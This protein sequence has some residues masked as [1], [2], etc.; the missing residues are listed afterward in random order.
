MSCASSASIRHATAV[1]GLNSVIG[2]I[3]GLSSWTRTQS[4][5]LLR[6]R[7]PSPYIPLVLALYRACF[8]MLT[9]TKSRPGAQ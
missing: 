6:K 8:F 3:T 2:F 4:Y 1:R 5:G 7:F 9:N